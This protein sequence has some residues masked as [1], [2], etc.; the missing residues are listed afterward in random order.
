MPVLAFFPHLQQGIFIVSGCAIA[1]EAQSCGSIVK[2]LRSVWLRESKHPL[3]CA[4]RGRAGSSACQVDTTNIVLSASPIAVPQ[5]GMCVD[6]GTGAI[7]IPWWIRSLFDDDNQDHRPRRSTVV[8]P[9][10]P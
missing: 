10:S 8:Y 7:Q 1:G 5:L 2:L 9:S 6:E 3:S 4:F